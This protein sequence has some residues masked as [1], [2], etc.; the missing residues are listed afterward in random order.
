MD[1]IGFDSNGEKLQI[2]DICDFKVNGKQYEGMI[3]YDEDVFSFVFEMDND[4]FPAV[5]MSKVDC[6]SIIKISNIDNAKQN[7][8]FDFYKGLYNRF[9]QLNP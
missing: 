1:Y 5:I 4:N 8:D 7:S 2:Y 3:T 6:D 9:K